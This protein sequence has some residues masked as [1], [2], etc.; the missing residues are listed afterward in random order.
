MNINSGKVK[1][2]KVTKRIKVGN[3]KSGVLIVRRMG[4]KGQPM[5]DFDL[6]FVKTKIGLYLMVSSENRG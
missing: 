1:D 4:H 3:D 2:I 6:F 5:I